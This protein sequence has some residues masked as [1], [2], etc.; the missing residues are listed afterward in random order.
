MLLGAHHDNLKVD[1]STFSAAKIA[2]GQQNDY[3]DILVSFLKKGD[4]EFK[5]V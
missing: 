2:S 3:S 4:R 5:I 1:G